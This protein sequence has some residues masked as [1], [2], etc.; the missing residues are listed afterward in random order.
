MKK[1]IAIALLFAIA[2]PMAAI[3]E[4]QTVYVGG[5][6]RNLKEGIVGRLDTTQAAVLGFEYSGA[7]LAIPWAKIESFEYS[8]QLARHW[9][10]VPTVAIVLFKYRQRRHFFRIAY[11]DEYNLPQAA[12]F[13][14]PK[15]LP[16][17]L[18]AVLQTRAP[19]G[20]NARAYPSCGR[21]N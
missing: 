5:T 6:V 16:N 15:Q 11:R 18:L 3:D 10:I 7:W 13:E 21:R 2:L 12:V 19:Q 1:T 14:V 20:C 8:R 9:G 4:G 17:T